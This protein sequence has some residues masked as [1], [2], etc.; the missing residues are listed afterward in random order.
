[1]GLRSPSQ[2]IISSQ[3]QMDRDRY[4]EIAKFMDFTKL[5][6]I[7]DLESRPSVNNQTHNLQFIFFRII[8][9]YPRN[10][11]LFYG[12]WSIRLCRSSKCPHEEVNSESHEHPV[13]V[14]DICYGS[15]IV[16]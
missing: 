9:S 11:L 16:M 14:A 12:I 7:I 2:A 4:C 8:P 15:L 10:L 6:A 5:Y 1:M 13:A 3:W